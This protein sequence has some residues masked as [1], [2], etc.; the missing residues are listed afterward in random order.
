MEVMNTMY[1]LKKTIDRFLHTPIPEEFVVS[2]VNDLDDGG[3]AIIDQINMTI[4]EDFGWCTGYSILDIAEEL[5]EE[6]KAN[7]NI[8]IEEL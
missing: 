2:Y 6:S 1:L 8:K 5:I 3:H 4:D 7:G